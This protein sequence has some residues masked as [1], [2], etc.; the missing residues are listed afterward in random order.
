MISNLPQELL[1]CVQHQDRRYSSL[2]LCNIAISDTRRCRPRGYELPRSPRKRGQKGKFRPRHHHGH[3]LPSS[4]ARLPRNTVR[5][6]PNRLRHEGSSSCMFAQA[7]VP[8]YSSYPYQ[9]RLK[10]TLQHCSVCYVV[11]SAGSDPCPE[12]TNQKKK[13]EKRSLKKR[14]QAK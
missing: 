13:K 10:Y 9:P 2:Y 5:T 4:C 12:E 7:C 8:V 11:P 14:Y 3:H 6:E 1:T